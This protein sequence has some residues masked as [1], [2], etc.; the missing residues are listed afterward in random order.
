MHEDVIFLSFTLSLK[1]ALILSYSLSLS[2]STTER[3]MD[4]GKLNLL[5]VVR[6]QARANLHYCPRYL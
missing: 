4:L 3:F 6:F 2:L 5:M 1:H